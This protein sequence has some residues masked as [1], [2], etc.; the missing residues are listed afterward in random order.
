MPTHKGTTDA[1]KQ[2][3][4]KGGGQMVGESEETSWRRWPQAQPQGQDSGRQREGRQHRGREVRQQ[5]QN[6]D[7][8]AGQGRAQSGREGFMLGPLWD[9]LDPDIATLACTTEREQRGK[10]R[11]TLLLP[12]CLTACPSSLQAVTAEE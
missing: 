5:V 10:C 12:N 9:I 11:K 7:G 2:S 4:T 8:S 6:Q 3:S 1:S